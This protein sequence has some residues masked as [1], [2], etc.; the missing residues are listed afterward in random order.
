MADDKN[1]ICNK[2]VDKKYCAS[3]GTKKDWCACFMPTSISGTVHKDINGNEVFE[4]IN[5]KDEKYL[6]RGGYGW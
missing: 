3:S 6:K 2:C 1:C 4:P 5:P